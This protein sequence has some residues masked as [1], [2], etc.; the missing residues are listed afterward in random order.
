MRHF[1][2]LLGQDFIEVNSNMKK[3]EKRKLN[4]CVTAEILFLKPF[5]QERSLDNFVAHVIRNFAR[6]FAGKI[7]ERRARIC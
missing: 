4:Q 6:V 5:Y 1:H 2:L 7:K 3:R